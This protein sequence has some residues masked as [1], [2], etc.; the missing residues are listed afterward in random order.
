MS[1]LILR[2]AAVYVLIALSG[3]HSRRKKRNRTHHDGANLSQD[4]D[5]SREVVEEADVDPADAP[6]SP[7]PKQP[8]KPKPA[9]KASEKAV[10]HAWDDHKKGSQYDKDGKNENIWHDEKM[11]EQRLRDM[12]A[13]VQNPAPGQVQV[14]PRNPLDPRSGNYHD[15]NTHDSSN[16]T[17][18]NGQTGIRVVVDGDGNMV[19]AFPW[20]HNDGE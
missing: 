4:Q 10:K 3:L 7:P 9:F 11:T 5:K 16:P 12:I 17:G 20:P 13:V 15:Y 18:R 6:A 2:A 19:T 14:N 1:R 8:K